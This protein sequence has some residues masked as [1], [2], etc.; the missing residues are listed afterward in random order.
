M[1]PVGGGPL[2]NDPLLISK[3]DV[4]EVYY[5]AMHYNKDLWRDG[6]DEYR[7]DRWETARPEWTYTPFGGGPRIC[8]GQRLVYTVSAYVLMR[9]LRTFE[10]LE[11]RDPVLKWEEEM[12]MTFQSRNG[13]KVG[14]VR[15]K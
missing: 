8:P 6:A 7:P 10:G 11:N 1:I 3:G 2:G 13:T 9:M 15:G 14:L 5:R 4:L 12:R